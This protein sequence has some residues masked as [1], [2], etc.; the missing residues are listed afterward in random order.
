MGSSSS[1]SEFEV[2]V[3]SAVMGW[4]TPPRGPKSQKT[5]NIYLFVA[6]HRDAPKGRDQW[7]QMR[8]MIRTILTVRGGSKTVRMVDLDDF[9]G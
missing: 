6:A 2:E 8:T 5:M 7:C 4:R 9:K 3:A 1:R